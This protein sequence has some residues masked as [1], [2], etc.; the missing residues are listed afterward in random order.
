MLR[1]CALPRR[2]SAFAAVASKRYSGG[3]DT[4]S[5]A[6][7]SLSRSGLPDV[8]GG[9][10][11]HSSRRMVPDGEAPHRL[12]TRSLR[13]DQARSTL[14][15][16]EGQR[17]VQL[18]GEPNS[19]WEQ[20][21]CAL[22]IAEHVRDADDVAATVERGSCQTNAATLTKQEVEVRVSQQAR[23]EEP[24]MA[25]RVCV[26]LGPAPGSFP[27]YE[28]RGAAHDGPFQAGIII[29]WRRMRNTVDPSRM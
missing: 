14:V 15:A 26:S 20:R 29:R 2:T 12:K 18:Q 5:G 3:G 11:R 4:A 21:A 24:F 6:R 19:T 10:H 1:A 16:H 7:H 25:S 9:V 17:G 28:L 13:F 8:P 22:G 27:F 23:Q